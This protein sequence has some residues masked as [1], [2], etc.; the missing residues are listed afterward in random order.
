M[1]LLCVAF[2]SACGLTDPTSGQTS[3]A[4]RYTTVVTQTGAT[5]VPLA[6]P[7][8]LVADTTR[9]VQSPNQ[10]VTFQSQ[11]LARLSASTVTWVPVT[12]SGT[13][14]TSA[15]LTGTHVG[16][17]DILSRSALQLEDQRIGG[18]TFTVNTTQVDTMTF[19][20]LVLTPPGHG[21]QWALH[22]SGT[23]ISTYR[24][25]G[26]GGTLFTSCTYRHTI[27]GAREDD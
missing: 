1:S 14:V 3:L 13:E 23:I 21:S 24:D 6:L 7:A 11:G 2:A 20:G 9:Y 17:A 4:G 26:A 5:C 12:A 8:P 19:M 15:S 27:D 25:G 10:A 16:P 22:A 18:H